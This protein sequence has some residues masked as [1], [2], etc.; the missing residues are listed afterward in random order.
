MAKKKTFNVDAFK[1]YVNKQLA[2]VDEF[3]TEAFKAGLSLS[4]QEVLMR[5]GNYQGFNYIYWNER[6]GKEWHDAGEPD[7]PEKDKYL[8]GEGGHEYNRTYH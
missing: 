1:E 6:G 3:A 4:L 7:F 2:R 8:Y 5:S